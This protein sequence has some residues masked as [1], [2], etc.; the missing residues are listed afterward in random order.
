MDIDRA[1]LIQLFL[2]DSEE[3]LARLET[4]VL[5][6][7][8]RPN[9]SDGVAAIFRIAHTLKG[10][11][12]ILSLDEFARIAHALEDVLHLVRTRQR[13]VTGEL[14]TLVLGTVDALRGMLAA[15]RTGEGED[16]ARHKTLADELAVFAAGTAEKAAS[17]GEGDD[18]ALPPSDETPHPTIDG[19]TGPALR[20]E[21]AKVDQLL[22][23]AARALVV[24][25]QMG[26][27]LSESESESE[28]ES[29]SASAEVRADLLELHQR[30]ERLLMELQDWIIE[31]RM[32]PV[33]TFFRSHARGVRD[34]ARAQR[35][36]ARLRVEGERVRVDTGIGESARDVLT[37][38]VRNAIDHGIEP[39]ALRAAQGK[40]PERTIVLRASQNGNQVVIQ[41]AD[42]GA[43]FNLG[44]IRERARLLGRPNA[45]ALTTEELHQMVF[46]PGFTTAEKVTAM[47]G[48]GVGMDVVRRNVED[49][50]GTVDVE[51]VEG[52]GTTVELR[53]PLSLSVIEGFWVD[54]SGT[55]Y[56]LP[57]DD[58]VEC[59]EL[60]EGRRQPGQPGQPQ[61][62][63]GIV[64]LRGEPLAFVH[65]GDVLDA[66]RPTR[67][68]RQVVVVRHRAT[69]V[70]LGVDAI[71][72]ERQTV[73]K[74]LGRLFR[75]VA[76]IS[77]STMR[78]DGTV[79]FVIDVARLLRSAARQGVA[80]GLSD[81]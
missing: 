61:E 19:R 33:S 42:D 53:L 47:S 10:N 32:L 14:V 58:V 31:A 2:S 68:V 55:D 18:A 37:H 26:A 71:R 21:M 3:D 73:I 56:V 29:A 80:P 60:G 51:S 1:A 20:I 63:G 79:A 54:V 8:D 59:L 6:L 46:E 17:A 16:P 75:S 41:V 78:P 11:A 30:N 44:K 27:A 62:P 15:L 66:D 5:A 7:E 23:L 67:P 49:L 48:R 77:G 72:G 76:G 36:R 70:G 24:Q 9:D 57:L 22:D 40:N 25:G 74:P 43:G 28:S 52:Q 13:A 64:D 4:S 81:A 12:A 50:H 39:P 34:A 38:L 35:K 65:L 45:E 69:R